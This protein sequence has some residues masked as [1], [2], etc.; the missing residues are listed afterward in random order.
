MACS[1]SDAIRPNSDE[2]KETPKVE[3]KE[4]ELDDSDEA[5][6]RPV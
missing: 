3:I 5:P 1:S 4:E 6:S 2:E